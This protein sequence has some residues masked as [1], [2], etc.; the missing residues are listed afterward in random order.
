[1]ITAVW[2]LIATFKSGAIEPMFA[3]RTEDKCKEEITRLV[4]A[5]KDLDDIGIKFDCRQFGD[6]Q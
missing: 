5:A 6:K 3:Y 1:M 4:G 2:V